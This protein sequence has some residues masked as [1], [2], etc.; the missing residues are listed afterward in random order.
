[1]LF[2]SYLPS[3]GRPEATDPSP[4][5]RSPRF[6]PGEELWVPLSQR[7]HC[8]FL[9]D[10]VPCTVTWNRGNPCSALFWKGKSLNFVRSLKVLATSRGSSC[11]DRWTSQ[12]L[13]SI[14]TFSNTSL[15]GQKDKPGPIWHFEHFQYCQKWKAIVK[16]GVEYL[17]NNNFFKNIGFFLCRIVKR[18]ESTVKRT[19]AKWNMG[20]TSPVQYN[21]CNMFVPFWM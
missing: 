12:Q 10:P 9:G 15:Q 3:T 1:M 21:S 19:S 13:S 17:N 16:F 18:Y 2:R 20:N 8:H 14:F 6:S 4:A 5:G 7:D 11:G